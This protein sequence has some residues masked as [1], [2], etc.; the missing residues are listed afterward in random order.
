MAAGSAEQAWCSP[1]GPASVSGAL[2]FAAVARV[3]RPSMKQV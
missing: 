3:L 1:S 2:A